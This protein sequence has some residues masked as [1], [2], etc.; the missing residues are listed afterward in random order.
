M[1]VI[2]VQ[3]IAFTNRASPSNVIATCMQSVCRVCGAYTYMCAALMYVYVCTQ[4]ALI[5]ATCADAERSRTILWRECAYR[6]EN[7][8]LTLVLSKHNKRHFCI[9]ALAI[10]IVCYFSLQI[11]CVNLFCLQFSSIF[12]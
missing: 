8:W 10:I 6:S 4:L 3:S 1:I 12:S 7:G 9:Y 11:F 2:T 5:A